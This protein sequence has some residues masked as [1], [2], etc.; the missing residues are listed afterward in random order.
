M[1]DTIYGAS[2]AA[3]IQQRNI[4]GIQFHPEKSQ[5]YGLDIMLRFAREEF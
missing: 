1:A 2:I 3:V 4:L 5:K